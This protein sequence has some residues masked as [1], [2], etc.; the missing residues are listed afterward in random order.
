MARNGTPADALAVEL[1]AGATV[2]D[3]A[4]A[5]SE[6]TAHRRLSDPAFKARV[7]G[8]RSAMVDAAVGRLA[9]AMGEA[10]GTLHKLLS[11][12]DPHVRFKAAVKVLELGSNL[13][14]VDDLARQVEELR[15]I[16]AD[17]RGDRN[18]VTANGF[19][20]PTTAPVA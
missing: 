18:A 13:A 17:L 16:L 19:T 12:P 1:A 4:A 8:L 6:R 10:A 9:N 15:G 2:R 7:R 3:A 14:A 11:D 20:P 5:V